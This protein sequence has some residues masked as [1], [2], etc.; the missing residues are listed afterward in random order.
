MFTSA[1]KLFYSCHSREYLHKIRKELTLAL[2]LEDLHIQLQATH[3]YSLQLTAS[4]LTKK[5]TVGKLLLL[6]NRIVYGG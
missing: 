5:Q 4:S 3:S 2:S 6:H 1:I